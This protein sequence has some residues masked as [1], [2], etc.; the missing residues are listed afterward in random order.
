MQAATLPIQRRD[1]AQDEARRRIATPYLWACFVIFTFAFSLFYPALNWPDEAY[2]ISTLYNT[3]NIYLKIVDYL[4]GQSCTV[5]YSLDPRASFG[6]NKLSVKLL[7]GDSCYAALKA[8]NGA[9]I[10][11][12]SAIACILLR[13]DR[14][15]IYLYSI[16]WPASMFYL[17][18][19]NNQVVF[20]IVSLYIGVVLAFGGRRTTALIISVLLLP[21]DRSFIGLALFLVI[22]EAI[23]FSRT[24]L[25]LG[26]LVF[27][28]AFAFLGPTI[29]SVF[30]L[31]LGT[32]AFEFEGVVSANDR[33]RDNFLVNIALL[34]GSFVY[35]GGL[36]AVFGYG[37]DY[38]LSYVYGIKR[39]LK[40]E[41]K[42][43]LVDDLIALLASMLVIYQAIPTIATFRY[44][45]FI[46][47]MLFV[48]LVPREHRAAYTMYCVVSSII[49]LI[50]S[51]TIHQL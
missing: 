23:G 8:I 10:I 36:S 51:H 15:R 14:A 38:V 31:L 3:D 19:I 6:S 41:D 47:P 32:G 5:A 4:Q 48:R 13:G 2:K 25:V 37:I 49:Y 29:Q 1:K 24:L 20:H 35:L 39:F 17:T 12:L 43:P 30:D 22:R 33:Y 7:S 42:K 28:L 34:G 27:I 16:I 45:V 46:F 18:S 26:V 40:V 11:L 21:I 44:Y 9:I 50:M